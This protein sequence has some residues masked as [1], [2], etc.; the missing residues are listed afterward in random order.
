M[1]NQAGGGSNPQALLNLGSIEQIPHNSMMGEI[2]GLRN[3]IGMFLAI[4]TSTM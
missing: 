1:W 2:K 3:G 4:P